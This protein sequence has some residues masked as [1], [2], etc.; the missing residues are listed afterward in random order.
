MEIP[1]QVNGKLRG[2]IVVDKTLSED[3]IK[4][5]ALIEVKAYVENGYKKIIYIPNRIFNIVV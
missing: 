1:I 5:L 2:K 3:E 4:K